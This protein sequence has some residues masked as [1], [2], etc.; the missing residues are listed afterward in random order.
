MI[1]ILSDLDQSLKILQADLNY[2][3]ECSAESEDFISWSKDCLSFQEALHA[4]DDL[5]TQ[6]SALTSLFQDLGTL[7]LCSLD[8]RIKQILNET[9]D[10]QRSSSI[11]YEWD[12]LEQELIDDESISAEDV[13]QHKSAIL[14]FMSHLLQE[15]EAADRANPAISNS[16]D[17][18]EASSYSKSPV[19]PSPFARK[20]EGSTSEVAHSTSSL[21]GS[22]PELSWKAVGSPIKPKRISVLFVDW[23]NTGTPLFCNRHG[24]MAMVIVWTN[25]NM[26]LMALSSAIANDS[27][28]SRTSHGRPPTA[29]T[30]LF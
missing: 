18:L 10:R 21:S 30:P 20:G 29:H 25:E 22:L 28:L 27:M 4:A 1:P 17:T 23:D 26:M 14:S 7:V 12:E 3:R 8:D 13:E 6:T 11:L 2:L 24:L 15:K 19:Q 16:G 5:K 9:K